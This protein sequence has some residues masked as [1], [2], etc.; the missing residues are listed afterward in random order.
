MSTSFVGLKP[1]A[2]L[3]VRYAEHGGALPQVV[4]GHA[5]GAL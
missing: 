2:V 4:I 3:I 1:A 5:V